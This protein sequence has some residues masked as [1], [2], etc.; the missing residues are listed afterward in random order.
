MSLTSSSSSS[1][2]RTLRAFLLLQLLLVPPCLLHPQPCRL[3]A[4]IGHSVRVGALLPAQ[5][6]ARVQ[7]QAALSRAAAAVSRDRELER[8]PERVNFLPYNL[9]LELVPRQLTAADPE[10][11]LRCACQGVVVQGVSAVLAFPQSREELLQVDLTASSLEIPFISVLQHGEPL[12]T[13]VRAAPARARTWT[14]GKCFGT[15]R[16]H[17]VRVPGL[18]LTCVTSGGVS[19]GELRLRVCVRLLICSHGFTLKL[20]QLKNRDEN[21]EENREQGGEHGGTERE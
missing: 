16:N 2:L 3:L 18:T 17:R 15:A 12:H 13:Q 11:L 14:L 4:Q 20:Q 5:R 6:A 1:C 9:S 10:S 21:V 8:D 7:V 19:G